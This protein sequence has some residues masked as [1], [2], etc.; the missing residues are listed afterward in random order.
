VITR[1]HHV[2]IVVRS[3]ET[4]FPFFRDRLGLPLTRVAEIPD[5]G[6]RAAL[7][8]AGESEVELL[9]PT[10]AGTGVARFLDR[11]GEGMHHLCFESDG[12]SEELA[13]LKARGVAL[14]D[15]VPRPGLAGTIAFLH[16]RATA[17]VLVE[18]ATPIGDAPVP[19]S[20]CRVRRVVIGVEEPR[21]TAGLYR[22]LFGLA[23]QDA[24]PSGAV[25][26]GTTRGE[27][28]L[29]FRRT[30]DPLEPGLAIVT[31]EVA[32]RPLADTVRRALGPGPSASHGV[33]FALVDRRGRR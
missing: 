19:G 23:I 15:E 20:P 33:T 6:V 28:L 29:E 21:A 30:G 31:L 9:E 7:L 17:G 12:V 8:A 32:D 11:R 14:I 24:E 5:Q 16:P 22:E 4:A 3:L 13:R 2:G 10:V 1:V 18:L 26:A 25:T 27:V